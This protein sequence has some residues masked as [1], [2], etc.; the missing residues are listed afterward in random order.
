MLRGLKCR[1]PHSGHDTNTTP[2]P[3]HRLTVMTEQ[4]QHFRFLDIPRETRD[5]IDDH[6]LCSFSRRQGPY[7]VEQYA[8]VYAWAEFEERRFLG[9]VD[10]LLVNK[11]IYVEGHEYML[12]RNL[13][14]RIECCGFQ[15]GVENFVQPIPHSQQP[16]VSSPN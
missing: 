13:F 11:Q 1:S 3:N 6:A 5:E 12:K 9:T 10:L 15:S 14:V 4:P 7:S 8:R 2:P 16:I